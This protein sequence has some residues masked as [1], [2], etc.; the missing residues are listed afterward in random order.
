[1]AFLKLR[2]NKTGQTYYIIHPYKEYD[3]MGKVKNKKRWIKVGSKKIQAEN[4]LREFK[5]EHQKNKESFNRHVSK[6]CKEFIYK[7]YLPWCKSIK[8]KSS[9]RDTKSSVELF[10]TFF[11]SNSLADINIRLIEKF[12]SWRLKQPNRSNHNKLT[13][14]S[15]RTLNKELVYLKQ[16][17]TKAIEWSFISDNPFQKIKKLKETTRKI[18]FFSSEEVNRLLVNADEYVK[19]FLIV[20]LNT[21]MRANEIL[22][23]RLQD[24]DLLQNIVHVCNRDDFKTKNRR[25]RSIPITPQLKDFLSEYI[26]T[27]AEPRRKNVV[28]RQSVQKNFLF[29]HSNGKKLLS[30]GKAFNN[31]LKRNDIKDASIHTMRHTFASHLVMSGVDLRTVQELLG[32]SSIAVTEKYAHLSNEH[33]QNSIR[34]LDYTVM[35]QKG[36]GTRDRSEG[37]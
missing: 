16:C 12:I 26:E 15:A 7:E 24:I 30:F 29:C 33:K 22:N 35:D 11:S 31:H 17:F 14:I 34:N 20:G 9:Y 36:G 13:C 3:D 32:H 21:G 27:W 25:D 28:P 2:K 1:M 18:R 19:R 23:I 10:S 6:S 4:A 37:K 8:S 5:K